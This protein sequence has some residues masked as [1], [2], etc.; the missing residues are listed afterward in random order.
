MNTNEK[1]VITVSRELGSGGHTI[2]RKLADRLNV[3]LY[4]KELIKGL[5]QKFDLT[6]TSIERLKGQKK[7][8]LSDFMHFVFPAPSAV[9]FANAEKIREIGKEY[10]PDVTTEDIFLAE[11]EILRELAAEESCVIA[12]R[13]GFFVLKDH[14]NK[15]DIF[16][17]ASR[18]NRIAR[19]MDRQNLDKEMA[20][21]AIDKVDK[22]RENYI[23][24]FSGTSRYDARNYHLCLN[25]DGMTEDQ[26]VDVIL[27]CLGQR[28]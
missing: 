12:G 6:P 2:A 21:E 1:F 11:T 10:N 5:C 22:A 8:W 14:P 27:A 20:E 13:S 23:Q 16:I 19:V 24:R 17:T 3:H 18:E 15:L 26:A 4:D 25:V 9:G 7:N 28:C